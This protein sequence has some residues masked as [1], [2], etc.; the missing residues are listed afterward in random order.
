MAWAELHQQEL[1]AAWQTLQQGRAPI[2]FDPLTQERSI[3]THETG[4]QAGKQAT[5]YKGLHTM[6]DW[7]HPALPSDTLTRRS[8]RRAYQGRTALSHGFG[9]GTCN[10]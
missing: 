7:I 1:E 9:Q 6:H 5:V 8:E 2:K 10:K 4:T 3:R